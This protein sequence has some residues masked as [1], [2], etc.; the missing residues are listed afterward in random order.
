MGISQAR[1]GGRSPQRER[2]HETPELL[3]SE[4]V[5]KEGGCGDLGVYCRRTGVK[6]TWDYFVLLVQLF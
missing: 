6:G 2:A 5:L 1:T 4:E 3:E